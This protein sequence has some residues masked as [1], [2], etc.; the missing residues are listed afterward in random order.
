[1]IGRWLHR[2]RFH[3]SANKSKMAQAEEDFQ[4]EASVKRRQ[5]KYF[6]WLGDR[7]FDAYRRRLPSIC[8]LLLKGMCKCHE[9]D[10]DG[11]LINNSEIN[12]LKRNI[13]FAV[14]GEP[15]EQPSQDN[16]FTGYSK[17]QVKVIETIFDQILKLQ[18]GDK[19]LMSV[20]FVSLNIQ[21]QDGNVVD[22]PVFRIPKIN[23]T[24]V[25]YSFIDFQ[26]R[27]YQSWDNFISNNKLP[28]AKWSYP[29]NGVYSGNSEGE[30]ELCFGVT[31]ETKL[32]KRV[33]KTMDTTTSILS[34]G[35]GVGVFFPPVALPCVV[36]CGAISLY[37]IVRGSCE[38]ADRGKHGQS[39]KDRESFSQWLSVAGS[40]LGLGSSGG[41]LAIRT[42][43]KEGKVVSTVICDVVTGINA[44]SMLVNGVGIAENALAIKEAE[45]W[46]ALQSFQLIASVLFF[47][48]SVVNF[49]TARAIVAECQIQDFKDNSEVLF[50]NNLE[51]KNIRDLTH[52]SNK[53]DFLSQITIKQT[54]AS[55][56]STVHEP[57]LFKDVKT[58]LNSLG[59]TDVHNMM[60]L[61]GRVCNRWEYGCY[62]KRA[63][64]IVMDIYNCRDLKEGVRIINEIL[65]LC[66]EICT[67]KSNGEFSNEDEIID[68]SISDIEFIPSCITRISPSPAN[69]EVYHFPED[70]C[71]WGRNGELEGDEYLLISKNAFGL[72]NIASANIEHK[73]GVATV[74]FEHVGFVAIKSCVED[75]KIV[76][77]TFRSNN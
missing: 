11:F 7:E 2:A 17:K 43:M 20:I 31:P 50:K 12:A 59:P 66:S 73:D 35:T 8:M 5:Q 38:L 37:S 30:V 28:K 26:G 72:A 1:M 23:E 42:M 46:N 61:L 57:K 19:I 34:V 36:T 54:A 62:F 29:Q 45:E 55:T 63:V 47:A 68:K 75:K 6:Q 13:G 77:R 40:A 76:V 22:F 65:R 25:G 67:S 60:N 24:G 14:F 70:H 3:N 21:C 49:K 56:L 53:P 69:E 52:I 27:I 51:Q 71:G 64:E 58:L 10:N 33:L 44:S 39:L 4:W 15:N 41:T 9:G 74:Y 16:T 48:H 32:G 18:K